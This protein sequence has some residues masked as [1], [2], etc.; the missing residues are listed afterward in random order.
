MFAYNVLSVRMMRAVVGL[1]D[2]TQ[3]RIRIYLDVTWWAVENG[4]TLRAVINM[5]RKLIPSDDPVKYLRGAMRPAMSTKRSVVTRSGGCEFPTAAG[6]KR[7]C[8]PPRRERRGAQASRGRVRRVA[9]R[10]VRPCSGVP[11]RGRDG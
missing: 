8:R 4:Q 7:P 6:L 11:G 2:A 5:E 10:G 9:V 3:L 1:R